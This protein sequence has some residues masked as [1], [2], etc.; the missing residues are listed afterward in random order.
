M[1]E[2]NKVL[3]NGYVKHLF[4]PGATYEQVSQYLDVNLQ[5]YAHETVIIH[6]GKNDLLNDFIQTWKTFRIISML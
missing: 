3:K 1:H 4:F 2:F 6:V 5:M